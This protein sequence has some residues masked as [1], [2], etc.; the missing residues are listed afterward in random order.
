MEVVFGDFERRYFRSDRL[1]TTRYIHANAYSD[2][3]KSHENTLINDKIGIKTF[4]LLATAS[5]K[6]NIL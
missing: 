1:S 5:K 2:R 3:S 4:K 6:S